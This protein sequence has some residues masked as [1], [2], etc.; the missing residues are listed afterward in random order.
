MSGVHGQAISHMVRRGVQHFSGVS[1]EVMQKLQQ[2]A[3]LY[4]QAGPEGEVNPMEFLPVVIT[5]AIV[6]LLIA[7]VSAQPD[8]GNDST[9]VA[10]DECRSATH[11]AK[12]SP[13]SP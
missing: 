1:P 3:Q 10:D 9:C 13:P 5:A 8:S 4:E 2:D 7:S 6:M 12:S 11:S